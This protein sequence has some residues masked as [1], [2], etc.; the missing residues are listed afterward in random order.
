[1]EP[2]AQ[3]FAEQVSEAIRLSAPEPAFDINSSELLRKLKGRIAAKP[4]QG[5]DETV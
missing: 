2:V 4:P 5:P 3:S 1:M